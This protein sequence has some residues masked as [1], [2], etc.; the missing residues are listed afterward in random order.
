MLEPEEARTLIII[1]IR[2][3]KPLHIT[4]GKMFP[5]TLSTFCNV[6]D[7]FINQIIS[8]GDNQSISDQYIIYI[9]FYIRL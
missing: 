1:M 2:A 8:S 9:H 6:R 5:M 3:N 7:T 4:A